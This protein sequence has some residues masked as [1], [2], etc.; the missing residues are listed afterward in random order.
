MRNGMTSS[1]RDDEDKDNQKAGEY[2]LFHAI[3]IIMLTMILIYLMIIAM[4]N[5]R[6]RV[7]VSTDIR[8]ANVRIFLQL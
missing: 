1:C 4:V 7:K 8:I 3:E 6:M 2:L 5:M